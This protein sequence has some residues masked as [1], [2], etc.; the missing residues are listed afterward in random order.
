MTTM[1]TQA[2]DNDDEAAFYK[3]GCFC[4]YLWNDLA[5]LDSAATGRDDDGWWRIGSHVFEE[6]MSYVFTYRTTYPDREVVRTGTDDD[7]DEELVFWCCD[8]Q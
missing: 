2:Q 1:M 4:S 6:M 3:T 7:D 5:Y 8:E